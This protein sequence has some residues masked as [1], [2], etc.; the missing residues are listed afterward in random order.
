MSTI[1]SIEGSGGQW[2]S[3]SDLGLD[4]LTIEELTKLPLEELE[5]KRRI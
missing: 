4:K 2:Y 1:M 5:L 3:D